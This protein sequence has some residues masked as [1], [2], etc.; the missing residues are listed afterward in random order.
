MRH[1]S[2][3]SMNLVLTI[4][5][6][7]ITKLNQYAIAFI[8]LCVI[9]ADSAEAKIKILYCLKACLSSPFFLNFNGVITNR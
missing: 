4:Y 6:Q 7:K 5:K 3:L 1:M 8:C 9:L 2:L